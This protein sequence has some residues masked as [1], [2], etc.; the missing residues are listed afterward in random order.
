MTTTINLDDRRRDALEQVQKGQRN[1]KL[2]I[3]VVALWEMML[4]ILIVL[5][6][7]FSDQLH[8]LILLS[9]GVV[10][11]TL[12]VGLGALGAYFRQ[13]TLRVL[14]AIELLES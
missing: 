1:F 14:A 11:G 2:M 7:D 8:V 9:T 4:L 12:A 5:L 3:G 6:V 13:N 10:Y